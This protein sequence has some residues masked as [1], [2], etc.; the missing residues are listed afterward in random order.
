MFP[1]KYYTLDRI[2]DFSSVIKRFFEFAKRN[3]LEIY[4]EFSLQF[5]L[6]FYLR[7]IFGKDFKIQLERNISFLGLQS[8]LIKKEIDILVYKDIGSLRDVIIVELKAIIDQSRA[9][10]ITVF[11]WITDLKFLEQLKS[12]GVG[13]CYSLF[14]TDNERLVSNSTNSNIKLRLLPDFRKRKIH[15]TYSTHSK[16]NKKNKT[17]SLDSEYTFQ[18]KEFVNGQKYFLVDVCQENEVET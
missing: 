4:N 16:P 9:R 17:I 7:E 15:G 5:E 2:M 3:D 14:V 10:P 8:D 12:A 18:W 6:S 1:R 11:N 13:S